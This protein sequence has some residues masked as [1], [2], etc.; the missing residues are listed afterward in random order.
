MKE[1]GANP[2]D[3]LGVKKVGASNV[4]ASSII[5]EALAMA[6]GARKYGPYNWRKNKVMAS[7]YVDAAFRHLMSWFDSREEVAQDSG[8]P[9]LA[10]AKAC[11]G[12][13][14]D[15]I[16]TGNLLDDRPDSGPAAQLLEKWK[17]NK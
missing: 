15:A 8:V 2:K 11:L 17:Q 3:I 4:P 5:Y 10:H 1:L 7:I 6:D 9:H 14:I 13:L 16:E 12:I